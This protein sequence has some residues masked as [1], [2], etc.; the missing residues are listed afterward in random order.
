MSIWA[1]ILIVATA[2]ALL[3]V[4]SA[5]IWA[6]LPAPAPKLG[7]NRPKWRAF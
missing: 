1:G 7:L 3:V 5:R 4:V 6:A 2:V